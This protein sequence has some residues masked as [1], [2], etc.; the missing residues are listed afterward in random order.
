ME[1]LA[2]HLRRH[3]LDQGPITVAEYMAAALGHPRHGYYMNKYPFGAGGDFVTAPEISQIFGELIGLW[4]AAVWQQ[5]DKPTSLHLVELGPGRGTLLS[6]AVRAGATVAGFIKTLH[7]HLVET[8]KLLRRH[9]KD[10]MKS[11]HLAH[12]PSWHDEFAEIPDGPLIVIAN[13]FFDAL[14][15]RQFQRTDGGWAER[16]VDND[17]ERHEGFRFVLSQPKEDPSEIELCPAKSAPVGSII[18]TRPAGTAIIKAVAERLRAFG[19]AALIIDYGH[20]QN[21]VGDTFQAVK[22]HAFHDPLMAP[23]DADLTA[24]VDFAALAAAAT[25]GGAAVH[26]ALPQG[27]FLRRLGIYQRAEKLLKAATD[28][29]A[30]SIRDGV[31]RLVSPK[32]MGGTFKAM[33]LTSATMAKPPGF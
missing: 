33:A 17:I 23:G 11:A 26:S 15:I 5:M 28:K 21:A 29:Q 2:D 1:S 25:V 20:T 22:E 3:I 30:S 4:C 27:E 6:D 18:E 8:S 7:P 14:P 9:Q 19:G 32:Q 31:S 12:S 10:T 24:H 16:L 13:E